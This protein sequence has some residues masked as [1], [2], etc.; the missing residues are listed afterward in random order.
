MKL[1][2]LLIIIFVLYKLVNINIF[3]EKVK[4]NKLLFLLNIINKFIKYLIIK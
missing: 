4:K 2:L 3:I 1:F